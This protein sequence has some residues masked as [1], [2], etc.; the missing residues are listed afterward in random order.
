M[1]KNI[2]VFVFSGFLLVNMCGCFAVLAGTAGGAGTAGWLSGKLTQE[3]HASYDRTINAAKSALRSLSLGLIKETRS[4][5]IT[6]LKSKYTDG[7][8]IWIDVR[9][10]SEDSTK[11]EVR[12]GA[13]NPDKEAS[14]KILKRIQR[15]L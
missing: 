1:L 15:Y 8:E 5:E 10:I 3:F 9:K 4:A 14:D 13:V 6:Q 12:V 11:V 2:M 7:K